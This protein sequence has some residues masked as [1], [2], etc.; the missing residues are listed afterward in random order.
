MHAN[1][2][3]QGFTLI[4]LVIIMVLISAGVLGMSSLFSISSTSLT[5]NEVRQQ[6]TQYAQECA[7]RVLAT[8]RSG[9]F[10]SVSSNAMCNTTAD[11]PAGLLPAMAT[12][13]TRAVSIGSSYINGS[14]TERC[15]I[16]TNTP[17]DCKDVTITVSHSGLS[18]ATITVMLVNY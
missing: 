4:E 2:Q 10:A 9:G 16:G 1:R 18:D 5:T 17:I 3:S 13:F 14:G 7:E 12:G 15:P 8:R 11:T 6:M